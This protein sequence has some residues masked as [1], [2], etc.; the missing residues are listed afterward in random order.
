MPYKDPE[1]R[2]AA[3]RASYAKHIETRRAKYR[4]YSRANWRR[5]YSA[6]N[7]AKWRADNP[8][9]WKE[10]QRKSDLKR[11]KT[12][13]YRAMNAE[14][15]RRRRT[16]MPPWADIAAIRSVYLE[17]QRLTAITGVRHEVDHILPLK[18]E[19]VSGLHVETNLRVIPGRENASKGNRIRV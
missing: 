10:L 7:A 3:N 6:S 15:M 5:F 11:W 2:R 4:G 1:K 18:S 19:T 9:R 13:K 17:A 16:S 8:E 14:K 12:P